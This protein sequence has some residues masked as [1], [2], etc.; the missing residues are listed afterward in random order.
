M[1]RQI[2]A[3]L[4]AVCLHP[5]RKTIGV[6]G[7]AGIEI[8]LSDSSLRMERNMKDIRGQT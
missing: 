1:I 4:G 7:L 8:Q 6:L 5:G 2:R 3:V